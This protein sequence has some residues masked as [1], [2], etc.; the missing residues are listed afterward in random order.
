L[1]KFNEARGKKELVIN[2]LSGKEMDLSYPPNLSF[3]GL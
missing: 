3:G 2:L 1:G